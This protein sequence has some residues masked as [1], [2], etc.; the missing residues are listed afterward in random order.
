MNRDKVTDIVDIVIGK[1]QIIH[2]DSQ[3]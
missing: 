2:S 3:Y 1:V